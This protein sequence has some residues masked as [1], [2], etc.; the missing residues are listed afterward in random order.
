MFRLVMICSTGKADRFSD[1]PAFSRNC[2]GESCM[3]FRY[4]TIIFG[5]DLLTQCMQPTHSYRAAYII[6]H[7][8]I[9]PESTVSW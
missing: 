9:S 3:H 8:D 7:G 1:H 6:E 4:A 5:V 2:I